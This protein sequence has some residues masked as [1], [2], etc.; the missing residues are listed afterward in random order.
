MRVF[1]LTF[2]FVQFS[3]AQAPDI[4][5][6][7][8]FGGSNIEQSSHVTKL[9][10]GGYFLSGTSLSNI[11]GNKTENSFNNSYDYW[12]LR[13]DSNFNILWQRTIGGARIDDDSQHDFCSVSILCNDGGFLLGGSS[14]SPVSGLKT[15][16]SFGGED[17]WLVKIDAFGAI[18]WQQVYGGN[19]VDNVYSILQTDDNGFLLLGNS[20]SAISG[21]KTEPCKGMSDLWIIKTNS[22][23]TIEWQKTLGGAGVE[24]IHPYQKAILKK[25]NGNFLIGSDS[26]S[27]VSGDKAEDSYGLSDIWLVEITPLGDIVWQKTIGGTGDD[28]FSGFDFIDG[29]LVVCSSSNSPVS[30]LK[31]AQNIGDFDLWILAIDDTGNIINQKTIGGTLDD[32]AYSFY[33]DGESYYFGCQSESNISG[34]KTENSRGLSDAWIVKT[35]A[36]FNVLWDKTMG[37]S[38]HD[39]LNVWNKENDGSLVL[40]GITTS[41]MSGD[42]SIPTFGLWDIWAVK[43]TPEGLDST[44]FQQNYISIYPNPTQDNVIIDFLDNQQENK[45]NVYDALGRIVYKIACN[46]ESISIILPQQ[47]GLYFVTITNNKNEIYTYKVIKN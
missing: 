42:I 36:S 17:Y 2:V 14:G 44:S 45:I 23:G 26:T 27:N 25:P 20:P 38:N 4:A 34:D 18:E 22:L 12:V 41:P 46:Q 35:D 16:P 33:Y 3:L 47:S 13:L 37:G 29:N 9:D 43:L 5:L 10:D 6:Q 15:L 1:F 30:G 21:N 19:L 8:I 28:S 11:S 32:W 39:W 7:Q 31:T 40:F 24:H